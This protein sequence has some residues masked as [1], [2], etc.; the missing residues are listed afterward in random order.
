MS[1][2]NGLFAFFLMLWVAAEVLDHSASPTLMI[3]ANIY[4]FVLAI[5]GVWKLI[6]LLTRMAVDKNG[7]ENGQA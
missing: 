7:S 2:G 6:E 1:K 5:A 4:E 3:L